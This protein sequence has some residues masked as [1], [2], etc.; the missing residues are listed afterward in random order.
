M[1]VTGPSGGE[2]AGR[3]CQDDAGQPANSA[4]LAQSSAERTALDKASSH[5]GNT[6]SY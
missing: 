2:G 6:P 5:H 4:G 3:V 1:L